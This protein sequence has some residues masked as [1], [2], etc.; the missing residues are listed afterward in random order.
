[1]KEISKDLVEA[2]ILSCV[3]LCVND[4]SYNKK[5]VL[6]ANSNNME[7]LRFLSSLN[8]NIHYIGQNPKLDNVK[9]YDLAIELKI[10]QFDLIINLD[11]KTTKAYNQLLKPSGILLINLKGLD[12]DAIKN[13]EFNIKM[14]FKCEGRQYLFLSNHFHPLADISV[15]KID[16]ING[17]EY[18]NIKIHE[19]AFAMPNYQKE[20][21]KGIIKN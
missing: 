3:G 16:M 5:D 1:M 8:A 2:E 6:V 7:L 4:F 14:P 13:A 21:L 20:A 12:V 19:A 17:L 18:Y 10:N 11:N 15:Q 9:S